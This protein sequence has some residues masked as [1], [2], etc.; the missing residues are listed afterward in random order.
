M[1]VVVVVV[2]V[3]AVAEKAAEVVVTAGVEPVRAA[4][5]VA[6]GVKAEE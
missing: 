2:T 1:V 4:M 6:A 3:E 5:A